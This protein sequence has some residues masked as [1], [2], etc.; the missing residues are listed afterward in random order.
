MEY[1][2]WEAL[3]RTQNVSIW[4]KIEITINLS[5]FL[6]SKANSSIKMHYTEKEQKMGLLWNTSEIKEAT[7][8]SIKV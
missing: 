2:G 6:K 4:C 1:V 5:Y 7:L 3:G 8:I